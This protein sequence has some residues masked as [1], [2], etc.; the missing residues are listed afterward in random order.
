MGCCFSKKRKTRPVAGASAF[1]HRCEPEDRDPPSPEETVKEV[2]SETPN[3][4]PRAESKLVGNGVVPAADERELEKA[5]KQDSVDA[6]VSDLGSCVSLSLATDERSEA[7]SESSVATSS[8]TGPERSPGRKPARRRPVS[9]DLGPARRAHAAAAA[10]YGVRSRSARASASPPPRHVPR[11]RSVRRS[12]SPAANRPSSERRRAASPAA[13]VQRKPPVP[14]SPAGRVSPRR[15]QE[16]A[17]PPRSATPPS[18]PEDDAVTA[19]S[20]PSTP[21]GSAGGDVEGGHG[22]GGD[23]GKESLENPLVSLEC[24]IFL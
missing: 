24:F 3:T 2:L 11:D 12:P 4:K 15:A 1:P 10:S 14:A 9:V 18:P 17:T 16:A 19:A 6:A 22:G 20:E 13:P 7:V 5:K 23:D 8:V 21:D